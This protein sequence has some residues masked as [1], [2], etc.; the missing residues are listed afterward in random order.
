[1]VLE[2]FPKPFPKTIPKPFRIFKVL[3]SCRP[4]LNNMV[5][6]AEGIPIVGL[7]LI[8]LVLPIDLV[9][10]DYCDLYANVICSPSAP[11]QQL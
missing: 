1:M 11:R 8:H 3:L 9:I 2:W 10:F 5:K 4:L 7:V 6:F